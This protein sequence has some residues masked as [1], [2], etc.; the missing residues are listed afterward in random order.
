MDDGNSQILKVG[1]GVNSQANLYQTLEDDEPRGVFVPTWLSHSIGTKVELEIEL[2]GS[3]GFA[4][5]GEVEWGRDTGRATT[6][7]G[8]G[9]KFVGLD[10]AEQKLLRRFA[11]SR[12]PML[13][14]E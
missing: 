1:L 4:C 2:P 14:D 7:P 11:N 3:D 10:E 12:P 6:W 5:Q 9:V 8:L 13:F